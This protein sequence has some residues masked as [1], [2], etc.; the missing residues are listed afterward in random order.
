MIIF[1]M[2][3]NVYYNSDNDN[4]NNFGMKFLRAVAQA[5]CILLG[6]VSCASFCVQT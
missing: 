5:W 1:I 4:N 6:D 2:G 3:D